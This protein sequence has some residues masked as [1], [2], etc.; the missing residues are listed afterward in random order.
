[1]RAFL[2]LVCLSIFPM[3]LSAS[4]PE[5][6]REFTVGQSSTYLYQSTTGTLEST[7]KVVHA[8]PDD[9]SFELTDT[10]FNPPSSSYCRQASCSSTSQSFPGAV[11]WFAGQTY[12][13]VKTVISVPGVTILKEEYDVPVT[14][15]AGT[16]SS[17]C[18]TIEYDDHGV[19][20]EKTCYSTDANPLQG[21][22]TQETR[23]ENGTLLSSITLIGQKH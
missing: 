9:A 1:M 21:F 2:I 22:V 23:L 19:R 11:R 8:S 15:P 3:A 7:W 5:K 6:W 10:R 20:I 16:F 13:W 14:T 17:Y 4:A 12:E 18:I